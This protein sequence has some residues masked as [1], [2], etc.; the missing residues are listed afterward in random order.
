MQSLLYY[1]L[2][3]DKMK[4]FQ[5]LKID[6]LSNFQYNRTISGS[7]LISIIISSSRKLNIKKLNDTML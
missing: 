1:D 5:F 2:A 6:N 7:Q 4:P 3:G